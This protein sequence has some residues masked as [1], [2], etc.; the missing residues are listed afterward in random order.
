MAVVRD[1]THEK[2]RD[3]LRSEAVAMAAHDLKGP[4]HLASG[5][6]GML[7]EDA[8][9]MTEDQLETLNIAQ[10]GLRR[11]RILIDDLLDLKKIEDGFGIVKRECQLDAVLRSV[12]DEAR[13]AAEERGQQLALHIVGALPLMQADPDR[14]HQ[15]FANLVGNAIK[16]T[17]PGGEV[18]V[19]AVAAGAQARVEVID[20]GPGITAEEQAH[21]F[22][23]FYRAHTAV[24]TEGTGLGLAIVKS[25]IEQHGG[26]VVVHSV[27][28]RGSRFVVTLPVPGADGPS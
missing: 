16:Y 8:S 9:T 1:I 24:S 7:A 14:L 27:P 20:N 22:Q 17:Q 26:Q 19:R 6:L 18:T 25:I 23:R 3:A 4:L 28:G 5:A 11:M 12:V 15:A 21:I 13:A 10:T 2:Q